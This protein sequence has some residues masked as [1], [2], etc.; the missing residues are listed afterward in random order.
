MSKCPPDILKFQKQHGCFYTDDQDNPIF[1]RRVYGV[2]EDD[3][4]NSGSLLFY[5]I[6]EIIKMCGSQPMLEKIPCTEVCFLCPKVWS[7]SSFIQ[8]CLQHD[9]VGVNFVQFR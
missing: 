2:P 9:H 4:K 6:F 7:F 8:T 1:V 5:C 3:L